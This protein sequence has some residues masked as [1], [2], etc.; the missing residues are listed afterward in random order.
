MFLE[1]T[2]KCETQ[3]KTAYHAKQCIENQ[4]F[5]FII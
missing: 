1:G 4:H 5:G 3:T 2:E